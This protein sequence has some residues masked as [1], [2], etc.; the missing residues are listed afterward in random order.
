MI[1]RA[2]GGD[3]AIGRKAALDGDGEFGA[4]AADGDEALEDALVVAIEEAVEGEDVFA[5]LGVDVECNFGAFGGER[6]VGADADGDV[7]AD[8]GGLHDDLLGLLGEE[9]STEVRDHALYLTNP[10]AVPGWHS[11]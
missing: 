5:D 4:D 3:E 8:A 9:A 7:V 10:S 6:G 2:E 11:G 1:L